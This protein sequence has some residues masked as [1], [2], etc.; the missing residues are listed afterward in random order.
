MKIAMNA[1][2]N[3]CGLY[4]FTRES[5]APGLLHIAPDAR[6]PLINNITHRSK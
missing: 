1:G 2:A 5:I 3:R 4:Q 6:S